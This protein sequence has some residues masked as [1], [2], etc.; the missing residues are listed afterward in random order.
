MK[1]VHIRRNIKRTSGQLL[2]GRLQSRHKGL[3]IIRL[4]DVTAITSSIIP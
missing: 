4:L 1:L 3:N 2:E